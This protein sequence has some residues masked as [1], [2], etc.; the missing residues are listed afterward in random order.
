[1]ANPTTSILL[2]STNP[3]PPT[4][5]QNAKPQ[6]DGLTPLQS[7]TMY[8]QKATASL[9]G[10]V[11]P[12]NTTITIDGTGKIS[13]SGGVTPA[14]IQEESLVAAADTG[15]ANAYAVTLSPAPT[16]GTYSEIVFKAANANTGASTVT[17][18]GTTYPL[19]KN[20]T[21]PLASGDIAAGQIVTAVSDGTNFQTGGGAAAPAALLPLIRGSSQGPTT[22][23]S[24]VVIPLPT[25]SL[26]GDFA[27]ICASNGFSGT[28]RG[29]CVGF[30]DHV[31]TTSE[32]SRSCLAF[33]HGA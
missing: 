24:S 30:Y 10:V 9:L 26:A 15:T 29:K 7:I 5:N 13:S 18:N 32:S 31:P 16:I 21:Q 2:N 25:G 22:N 27:I 3:A 14:Q 28:F 19:T 1:M 17:V 4:G 33:T 8:P 23:S 6:T 12:D 20:G 11:V